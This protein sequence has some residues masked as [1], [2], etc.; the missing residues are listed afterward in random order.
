MN[1]PSEVTPFGGMA[2]QGYKGPGAETQ[3]IK[4]V[5]DEKEARQE[6]QKVDV[7]GTAPQLQRYAEQLRGRVESGELP[8]GNLELAAILGFQ[9]AQI[10]MGRPKDKGMTPGQ[11]IQFLLTDPNLNIKISV[12]G[13]KT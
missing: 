4:P 5:R 6:T 12:S 8:R 3:M 9:P 11:L 10:A 1:D 7:Q 2:A 13:P